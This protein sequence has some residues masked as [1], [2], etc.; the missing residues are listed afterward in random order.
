MK[1]FEEEELKNVSG[2]EF[3]S[4]SDPAPKY[5]YNDLVKCLSAMDL[6]TGRVFET[7]YAP[8]ERTYYYNVSW[9]GRSDMI[10]E[11]DLIPSSDPWG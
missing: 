2:G 5:H 9:P 7:K 10:R 8:F 11:D 6:G 4:L 3:Q 1:K